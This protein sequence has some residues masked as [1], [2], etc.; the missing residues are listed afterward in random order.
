MGLDYYL[1][2]FNKRIYDEKVLPAH[3]AFFVRDDSHL[4]INLLREMIQDVDTIRNL[5]G[6]EP[7]IKRSYEEEI[8]IL[9]GSVFY[10][11]RGYGG[12]VQNKGKTTNEDKHYYVR[13]NLSYKIL[14]MICVPRNREVIPEQNM[15]RSLLVSYLFEKSKWVEELFAG[16]R[17]VRGGALDYDLAIG[18][19]SEL[20]TKED[21][22]EFYDELEKIAPP[23]E[24]TELIK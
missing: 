8:G 22:Q 1:H 4:L 10:N 24:G 21:I 16:G 9:D 5:P 11:A 18:E 17:K 2:L 14:E 20:F 7:G 13:Y 23:S 3:E 6:P 15:G 19:F 12:S